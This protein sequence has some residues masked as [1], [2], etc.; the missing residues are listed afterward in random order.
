MDER[1]P[2]P[3]QSLT[4]LSPDFIADCR[5][6]ELPLRMVDWYDA[7]LTHQFLPW[8]ASEEIL[9]ASDLTPHG[10]WYASPPA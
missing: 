2:A 9:E 3:T 7:P 6:R 8:C 1:E 4:F 5:A 10:S